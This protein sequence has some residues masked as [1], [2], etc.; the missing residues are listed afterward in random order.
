MEWI[1]FAAYKLGGRLT[2]KKNDKKVDV[3]G[4]RQEKMTGQKMN[5]EG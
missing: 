5:Q 1:K 2:G 3:A 4:D